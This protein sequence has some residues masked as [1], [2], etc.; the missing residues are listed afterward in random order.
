MNNEVFKNAHC[1]IQEG[2]VQGHF[3]VD[4]HGEPCATTADD[5]KQWCLYGAL[6]AA[7]PD[8]YRWCLPQYISRILEAG[9]ITPD[10]DTP[11]KAL[12]TW[13]DEKERQRSDVLALLNRAHM[14]QSSL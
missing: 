2:W 4:A 8:E 10:D 9:G 12:I 14:A 11:A 3:A 1:L 13:N 7:I 5:A 6:D